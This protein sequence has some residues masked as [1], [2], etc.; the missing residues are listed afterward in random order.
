MTGDATS[1]SVDGA[2]STSVL[3]SSS[4]QKPCAT[5]AENQSKTAIR[6]RKKS[7]LKKSG[8]NGKM[9]TKAKP[10]KRKKMVLPII[11]MA[12]IESWGPCESHPPENYAPADWQG[13][14]LDVLM[15][16]NLS[17]ENKI[18][19]VCHQGALD[20]R[21]Q[22]LFAV[23]CAR[24]A[25]ALPLAQP[26]DPRSVAACDAAERFA[27]DEATSDELAAAWDAAWAAAMDAAR[28]A[29]WDAAWD[30]QL[31]DLIELV[32]ENYDKIG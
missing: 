5:N 7:A 10:K 29:A 9:T 21:T 26:N 16:P 15:A 2:H 12:M 32:K 17:A 25:L 3:W 30:A 28:A 6:L 4:R 31:N 27:N 8:D 24:R 19:V 11:T 22:R 23:K 13:T 14:A 20:E 18:W 1:T